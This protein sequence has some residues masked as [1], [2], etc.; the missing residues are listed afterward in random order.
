MIKDLQNFKLV[1]TGP[2]CCHLTEIFERSP[3]PDRVARYIVEVLFNIREEGPFDVIF[4]KLPPSV[5]SYLKT[6][7][8]L[9]SFTEFYPELFLTET[10][11]L[12]LKPSPQYPIT[13]L[14][15]NEDTVS[16]ELEFRIL[17]EMS[18]LP[19]KSQGSRIF[20]L[21]NCDRPFY[22]IEWLYN[23]LSDKLKEDLKISPIDFPNFLMKHQNLFEVKG[24][25]QFVE[26]KSRMSDDF[27]SDKIVALEILRIKRMMSKATKRE[28]V[29]NLSSWSRLRI[30]GSFKTRD[31]FP[32]LSL[33][34]DF[35][36][37]WMN[38]ESNDFEHP[39]GTVPNLTQDLDKLKV[40]LMHLQNMLDER[41]C[42]M[43]TRLKVFD[44]CSTAIEII[45]G[46]VDDIRDKVSRHHGDE[47]EEDYDDIKNSEKL[48]TRA[49]MFK[50]EEF[51]DNFTEL[52]P[53]DIIKGDAIL[54]YDNC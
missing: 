54:N 11:S 34:K 52:A 13:T 20:V 53:V 43:T 38:I 15:K 40:Q 14:L 33:H 41:S 2:N 1:T 30:K 29:M 47:D 12:Q 28:I 24:G 18:K 19:H 3:V 36:S 8:S 10:K 25:R 27:P 32:F 35:F 6:Q 44:E 31:S 4:Q 16:E 50:D 39:N 5:R 46:G 48:E 51:D 9:K 21:K 49:D 7:E 17:E 26:A 45:I 42:G 22:S 37:N 23:N